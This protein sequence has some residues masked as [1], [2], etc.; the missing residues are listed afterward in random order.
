MRWPVTVWTE[1][2]MVWTESNTPQLSTHCSSFC[3]CWL[4]LWQGL[5]WKLGGCWWYTMGWVLRRGS[6]L[7]CPLTRLRRV[8]L[9]A[10]D[11]CRLRS[12]SEHII[13][14]LWIADIKAIQSHLKYA[15]FAI[16]CHHLSIKNETTHHHSV[17][18]KAS[19]LPG[20]QA[21]VSITRALSCYETASLFRIEYAMQGRCIAVLES[22]RTTWENSTWVNYGC[23]SLFCQDVLDKIEFFPIKC[24]VLRARENL[25]MFKRDLEANPTFWKRK[26]HP[27]V[28][29]NLRH[30]SSFHF[31][32]QQ[33]FQT[34]FLVLGNPVVKCFPLP[35]FLSSA[36]RCVDQCIISVDQFVLQSLQTIATT[37]LQI[38]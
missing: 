22:Q 6:W 11:K 2:Y 21:I 15:T 10:R 4:F 34:L 30:F 37:I 20:M 24:K 16:S 33:Q 13:Q 19:D 23:L 9:Q 3:R 27:K 7:Y 28:F 8:H 26:L 14:V 35:P 5:N 36:W 25:V 17:L 31:Q 18:P 38:I 12:A 1:P 32:Q 29:N